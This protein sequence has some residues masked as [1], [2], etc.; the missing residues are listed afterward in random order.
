MG[1]GKQV[2]NEEFGDG[3]LETNSNPLKENMG[4]QDLEWGWE[5]FSGT[6]LEVTEEI[7]RML[8]Q[9]KKRRKD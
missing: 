1:L 8:F 5:K 7:N 2:G 3:I 9:R 4:V 6:D